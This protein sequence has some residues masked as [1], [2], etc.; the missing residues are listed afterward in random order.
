MLRITSQDCLNGVDREKETL[1]TFK[2][3]VEYWHYGGQKIDDRGWGCGY[4]TLQTIISWFKMNLSL[5]STFPDI[6]DIQLALIDAGD[7]PRSFYKSHDWIG[8]VEAGIVVQHL[9]NTDYRIVQVPNGR[10]GKE[11]LAKIRDHF[12]RAGAP[13]MMGGIKDCSSKCILAM[14]KNENPDSASLLIL[15]PHY[16]TTDEEPD[17]PYLWR[18]GWL[19]WC[20]TEDLSETDFYNMCM[21]MA[22]YK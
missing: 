10:F 19:K 5:Q 11:H 17:L 9:T 1:Y 14:K 8:S 4:R 7:K 6:D 13:I 22:A 3:V 21:P 20:N 15:D 2:G 16:Y 18:E 12:Q